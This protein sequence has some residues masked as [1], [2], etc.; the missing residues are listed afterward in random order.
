MK[1]ID[2]HGPLG[3]W[4]SKNNEKIIRTE[5]IRDVTFVFSLEIHVYASKSRVPNDTTATKYVT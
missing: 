3:S 1:I 2:F 5:K 4:G